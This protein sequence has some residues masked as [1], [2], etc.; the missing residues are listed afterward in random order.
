MWASAGTCYRRQAQVLAPIP[1]SADMR[2]GFRILGLGI[3][4]SCADVGRCICVAGGISVK[5]VACVK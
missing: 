4:P 1:Y 3:I 5:S 2:L